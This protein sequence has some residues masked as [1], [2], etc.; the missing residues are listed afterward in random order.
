MSRLAKLEAISSDSF[1]S[2]VGPFAG[3][4]LFGADVFTAGFFVLGFVATAV[5]FRVGAR[6]TA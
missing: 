2:G 5:G 4:A 3:A 6:I 1:C